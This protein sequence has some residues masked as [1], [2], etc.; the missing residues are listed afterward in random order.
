M[1]NIVIPML[2]FCLN[3]VSQEVVTIKGTITSI[4]EGSIEIVPKN[5]IY[6]NNVSFDSKHKITNGKF[7]IQLSFKDNFNYPF[8][9]YI[10]DTIS[11]AEFY[12]N[13]EL[14]PIQ[15]EIDDLDFRFVPKFD[16]AN[17]PIN[18][19]R[20][21]FQSFL[22]KD[23]EDIR[24]KRDS[25]EAQYKKDQDKE[26]WSEQK[27]KL[28]DEDIHNYNQN[29]L[30]FIKEH[31]TS[32]YALWALISIFQGQ[33]YAVVYE[34]SFNLFDNQIKESS[35]G[36]R[37]KKELSKLK[38][39]T[40]NNHFP[41]FNAYTTESKKIK[42]DFAK[43][44]SSNTYT[45]VD[46]WFTSCGP[47]VAEYEVLKGVYHTYNSTNFEVIAVFVDQEAF[48]EKWKKHIIDNGYV[49]QNYLDKNSVFARAHN[50]NFF[51]QNFLLDSN[52]VI[53]KKNISMKEL[54]KFLEENL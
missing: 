19:E 10:N 52:G 50:I 7:E 32:N 48:Y 18:K 40:V 39:M 36:T 26:K 8:V 47:C 21:A 45:L 9:F 11:S 4:T 14:M 33:G 3:V 17:D 34:T 6:Y 29:L 43:L 1:K 30:E 42:L 37:L 28:T 13:K 49:W 16:K 38:S 41:S 23:R 53:L 25:I 15:V 24:K 20:L 5:S 44:A 31:P 35:I 27:R 51:P 12:L 46:F 22:K 2:F 54:A